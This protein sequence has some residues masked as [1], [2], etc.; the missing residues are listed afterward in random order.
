A[1][2][3]G[4]L[5]RMRG[6]RELSAVLPKVE[7]KLGDVVLETRGVGCRASGVRGVT[8]SVRA[9]EILGLAGLVGAGRTELAQVLFGLTPAD[10]GE[11]RLR[12]QPV[13]IDR[14]ARAVELGIAY[15]P[16]DRRRHGVILDMPVAG[17]A[18]RAILC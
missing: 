8:L 2:D 1:V 18:T 7:A 10:A 6:G 12:R 13:V 11:I 15:V 17:N 16:E 14:P 9:G 5:V 4:E 3:G